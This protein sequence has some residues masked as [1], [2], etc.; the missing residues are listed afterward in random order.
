MPANELEKRLV[1]LYR[2]SKRDMAEG[3]SNTLFLAIGFLRWRQKANDKKSFRAPLLLM[4]VKMVRRGRQSL[5]H[6]QRH[7]DE[8][9]FNST[10][11]QLLKKDFGLDLKVR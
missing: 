1:T 5:F 8:T 3:G 4:P 6:L 11:I 2:S 7:E 9:R 10:L